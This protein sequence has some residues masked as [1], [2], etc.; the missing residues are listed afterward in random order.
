M[1]RKEAVKQVIS[2]GEIPTPELIESM[3]SGSSIPKEEGGEKGDGKIGVRI[4][5]PERKGRLS[6]HDFT[7]FYNSKYD[8]L[9]EMLSSKTSAISIN[10][11]KN[12]FGE[13]SVIGMVRE[14][15]P[16]GYVI[17]DTTGQMVIVREEGD[18]ALGDVIGVSGQVKENRL[19]VK[20]V[21]FP[22]V[23][24]TQ[25]FG[26]IKGVRIM[27]SR[28]PAKSREGEIHFHAEREG[29][30][31]PNGSRIEI[32]GRG[33]VRML[34]YSPAGRAGPQECVESLKKRHL[35][36]SQKEISSPRDEFIIK[37]VPDILWADS[38]TRF[39]E[40]YKGVL[41]ISPGSESVCIDLGARRAY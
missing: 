31:L 24:L 14:K 28:K 34:F 29:G 13:V 19:F 16:A 39:V 26:S 3:L 27:L 37:D 4:F 5:T 15:T 40:S 38:D 2:R 20:G 17:E 7:S 11:A 23:P 30:K 36:I 35:I 10:K 1:D 33:T 9:K 12:T 21:V 22:D 41:I 25:R 18:L 6:S 32:S 8:G